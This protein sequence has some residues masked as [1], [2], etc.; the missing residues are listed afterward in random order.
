M[1]TNIIG[2]KALISEYGCSRVFIEEEFPDFDVSCYMYVKD[3][4]YWW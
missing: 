2:S 1:I 3:I 4:R